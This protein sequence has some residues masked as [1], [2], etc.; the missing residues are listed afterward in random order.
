M[1]LKRAPLNDAERDAIDALSRDFRAS[2]RSFFS[3]RCKENAEVDDLVQE[4]F[5]RLVKRSAITDVANARAY[6]FQTAQ[7]VLTDWLR[8]K[9][10]RHAAYQDEL[11]QAEIDR[12]GGMDLSPERVLVGRAGLAEAAAILSELPERTRAVF[13]LRRL[14]GLRYKDIAARLGVSVSAVERHMNRATLHLMK[15]LRDG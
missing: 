3:K 6:V 15:R 8:K 7:S 1:A 14:D 10:V 2:L 5:L 9:K 13:L 11:H 12:T 4:V